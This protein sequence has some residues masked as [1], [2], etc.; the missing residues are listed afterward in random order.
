[1]N[2]A[3]LVGIGTVLADD[4]QLTCRLPGMVDRSPVRVDARSPAAL[5]LDVHLAKTAREHPVWVS[6][7][8]GAEPI[9]ERHADGRGRRGDSGRRPRTAVSICGGLRRW[10][11]RHHAADGRGRPDDRG[12]V[13]AVPTS[14][15]R[16]VLLRGAG[17][18][19]PTASQPSRACRSTR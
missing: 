4:P 5:P 6:A 2:D 14:S 12:V 7:G 11:T 9:A 10:R 15:T 3:I 16:S 13:P 8:R 1:M 18:I 19:G 17:E